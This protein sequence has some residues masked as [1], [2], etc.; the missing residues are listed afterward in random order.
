[1]NRVNNG[2]RGVVGINMNLNPKEHVTWY[3][4]CLRIYVC[5]YR[6][7]MFNVITLYIIIIILALYLHIVILEQS[8]TYMMTCDLSFTG[9]MRLCHI[10]LIVAIILIFITT[11]ESTAMLSL[12]VFAHVF[13]SLTARRRWT[14]PV[15]STALIYRTINDLCSHP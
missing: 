5:V 12:D 15:P 3:V 8:W 10:V 7:M 1:M 13:D 4:Q 2:R 6:L 14:S 9:T 11:I